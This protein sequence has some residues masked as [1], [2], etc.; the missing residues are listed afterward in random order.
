M[1]NNDYFQYANIINDVEGQKNMLNDAPPIAFQNFNNIFSSN[2][3]KK[4]LLI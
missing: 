2:I 1:I 4:V 3:N